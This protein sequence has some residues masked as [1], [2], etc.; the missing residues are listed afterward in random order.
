MLAARLAKVAPLI[1]LGLPILMFT[2]IGARDAGEQWMLL[3]ADLTI[4]WVALLIVSKAGAG[5]SRLF[6]AL[7]YVIALSLL[8]QTSL[9]SD[10]LIGG[11]PHL[12]YYFASQTLQYGWNPA[13]PVDQNGAMAI[14]VL[15]P[16][17]SKLFS[18]DLYNVF[19]VI[20]PMIY[21]TVPVMLYLIY[22]R[23]VG[24]RNG[25]LAALFFVFVPVFFLEIVSVSREMV[26]ETLLVAMMFVILKAEWP[27]LWR[28]IGAAFIGCLVILAHYSVG[29]LLI[30]TMVASLPILLILKFFG[31]PQ[32]L[33]WKSMAA[34]AV[35]L[36][37]FGT[38]YYGWVAGGSPLV[39][40]LGGVPFIGTHVIDLG[41][42]PA[43]GPIFGESVRVGLPAP[44][45]P[46]VFGYAVTDGIVRFLPKQEPMIATALGLDFFRVGIAGKVFRF[47][48]LA[49]EILLAAGVIAAFWRVIRRWWSIHRDYKTFFHASARS[50]RLEM[51]AASAKQLIAES[52]NAVLPQPYPAEYLAFVV[53]MVLFMLAA[54]F[55]PD[56]SSTINASR[57]FHI[58]VLFAAP[59]MVAFAVRKGHL[60]F[61]VGVLIPYFLAGSGFL[62]E[63]AQTA[64]IRQF[65]LPY[66]IALSGHRLDL[67]GDFTA[68]DVEAR[69]YIVNELD[70][71]TPIFA[72]MYGAY[73][74]SELT[75][76]TRPVYPLPEDYSLLPADCYIWLRSY[77]VEQSSATFWAGPANRW[78][79]S[80]DD[81]G[82]SIARSER[83]VISATGDSIILGKKEG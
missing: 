70:D 38:L 18:M 31:V 82:L 16:F 25:V 58:A 55:T 6:P 1:S 77:D 56:F 75:G 11:D 20:F 60:L 15:A 54:V 26:S 80:F 28:T 51:K 81:C 52:Y 13:I 8:W 33:P 2:I 39:H 7:I 64:N 32:V 17:I 57:W 14:S 61:T 23:Y 68:A 48:Q 5:M 59:M 12:E 69:D 3:L 50:P 37:A 42:L 73:F 27:V 49:V 65:E 9:H 34:I 83:P 21:A 36:A 66:S 35:T 53:V 30:F 47:F 71:G 62:F 10:F 46:P 4:C 24:Q 78:T 22:R 76:L 43:I 40:L 19:K 45:D 67:W 79:R 72:D 41:K 74:I 63:V 44:T 29:G